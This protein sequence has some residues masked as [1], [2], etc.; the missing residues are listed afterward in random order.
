MTSPVVWIRQLSGASLDLSHSDLV[1]YRCYQRTSVGGHP[2]HLQIC[3]LLYRRACTWY[4]VHG[5]F[6]C[7]RARVHAYVSVCMCLCPIACALVLAKFRAR[8]YS[9]HPEYVA[10]QMLHGQSFVF[11]R[12]DWEYVFNTFAFAYAVGYRF[13]ESPTGACNGNFLGIGK[14]IEVPLSCS[15]FM[16][17]MFGNDLRQ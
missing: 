11:A 4:M 9:S 16:L 7:M 3:V 12:T 10:W 8:R 14:L 17:V 1:R 13:I 15:I 5:V 6:V 2:V